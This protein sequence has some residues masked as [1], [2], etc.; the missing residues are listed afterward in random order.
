L[1][2]NP[3][4]GGGHPPAFIQP[5]SSGTH[6]MMIANRNA[7]FVHMIEPRKIRNLEGG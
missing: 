2:E 4:S 7:L 3:S 1:H 6:A 5:A